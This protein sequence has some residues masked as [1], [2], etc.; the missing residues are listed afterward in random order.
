MIF[1]ITI[2]VSQLYSVLHQFSAGLLVLRL[3]E[4]TLGA[5][6]GIAVALLLTPLNTRDTVTNTERTV[7][8]T[9]SDLLHTTADR[10]EGQPCNQDIDA[11]ARRLH[12][13]VRQLLLAAPLVG[14]VPWGSG[15]APNPPPT[16]AVLRC[17][18]A[19]P[20]ACQHRAPSA[21][22]GRALGVPARALAEVAAALAD[23]P[24]RSCEELLEH[25]RLAEVDLAQLW[26]RAVPNRS[27]VS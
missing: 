21:R 14:V 17:H 25:V 5:A 26:S 12:D 9:L 19:H 3:E 20:P 11:Q 6:I 13:S 1:F 4:T 27:C 15:F 16:D 23:A 8:R 7:A 10:I 18:Q 22:H 24:D 2:M